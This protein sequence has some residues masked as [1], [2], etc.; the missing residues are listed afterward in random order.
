MDLVWLV[1]VTGVLSVVF[2]LWLARDVLGRDTGNAAMQDI[3][4]M[5]FEGAMAFLRR[6][7]GTIAVLS[8]VAVK[9]FLIDGVLAQTFKFTSFIGWDVVWTIAPIV[10]LTGHG[11]IPMSVQ[12]MKQGAVDFLTKP[13]SDVALIARVRS[14]ARLKMMTD[15]LR[16]RAL[17]SKEIG[18]QNPELEAIAEAG[19]AS[20]RRPASGKMKASMIPAGIIIRPASSGVKPMMVCTNTGMM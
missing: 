8:L 20:L 12:A 1:P 10:F 17:T 9:K 18:I 2:A 15:E 6:Q 19:K 13:V 11:D 3:A 16:M 14:L 4:G 7:Y 5:I